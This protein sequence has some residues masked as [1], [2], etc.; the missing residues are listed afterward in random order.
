M[1]KN[2]HPYNTFTAQQS[3]CFIYFLVN[4]KNKDNFVFNVIRNKEKDISSKKPNQLNNGFMHEEQNKTERDDNN[5]RIE[6][7]NEKINSMKKSQ[8]T[9]S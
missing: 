3:K 5:E 6:K 8:D 4:F 1:D 7:I 2:G 9:L